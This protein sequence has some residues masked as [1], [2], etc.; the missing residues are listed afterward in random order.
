MTRMQCNAPLARLAGM[1]GFVVAVALMVPTAASAFNNGDVCN[2]TQATAP[3]AAF[4]FS[5]SS[6]TSGDS[7]GFDAGS[8]TAGT[9]HEWTWVSA[10]NA[11]ELSAEVVTD[12][13]SSYA[14]SFGDGATGTGTTTSHSYSASGSYTAKLTVTESLCHTNSDH[15][16][17]CFMNSVTQP[18]TVANRPPTASFTITPASVTTGQSASFDA[19]ASAD[20]DGTIARYHWD[21]GDGQT[22]DTTSPV[23]AH[24]YNTAG[25]KAVTLT[26]TDNSG[27]TADL[28]HNVAVADRPPVAVFTAPAGATAGQ[29]VSFDASA[30]S[31]PDGT[32]ASY[33]WDFGDGQSQTT[34]IPSTSHTYSAPGAVTVTLTV[35]DNSGTTSQVQRAINV[36][37]APRTIAGGATTG[38]NAGSNIGPTHGGGNSAKCV[39]PNLRGDKLAKARRALAHHHCRLGRI[40]HKHVRKHNKGRVVA[41]SFKPGRTLNAGRAIGVTIGR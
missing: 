8:S 31:D 30:A 40:K 32:I 19:S 34:T 3:T 13:I 39:A 33:H 7:V 26:V 27:S 38:S 10:D 1:A 36:Q 25:M 16:L 35:T 9:A 29:A 4:T 6:P 15:T 2:Y 28:Q 20:P 5:P 23:I 17:T 22:Q 41:Q 11:C 14:W 24:V 21:F 18:V 37:P 12:P